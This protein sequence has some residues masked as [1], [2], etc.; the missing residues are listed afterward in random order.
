ME[1]VVKTDCIIGEGPVWDSATETLYFID[2]LNSRIF[3]YDGDRLISRK[4]SET[5]G[6]AVLREQGGM[7]AAMENGFYEVDFPA[8]R[9]VPIVDPEAGRADGRFNDGKVDPAGRF[10][11]GTMPRCLDSGYGEAGPD[12]GLYCLYPDG[13]VKTMLT[14]V[15]QANGLAWR[16]D[17]CKFY[18][19]DTQRFC[20]QEFDCDLEKNELSNGRVCVTVDRTL[21][22]PD[23]MTIDDEGCL[24]VALWGGGAVARWNPETGE[25]LEQI[26]VPALN[27]T[28]CCFGGKHLD[29]LYVT[30]ARL[31]TDHSQYPLAGSV[32]RFKPQVTGCPSYQFKG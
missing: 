32:F 13:S 11:A 5:I 6:C 9:E 12:S 23:G 29:E 7:V 20:V 16:R 1:L 3:S 19:I 27:V 24:W 8:G 18:F 14:E 2:L 22:I 28:S 17:G 25:L 26:P 30:T 15:I 31:N 4:M 10:W 21:G